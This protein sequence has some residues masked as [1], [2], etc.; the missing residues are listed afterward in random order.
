MGLKEST[1]GY[2]W[3]IWDYYRLSESVHRWSSETVQYLFGLG[4]MMYV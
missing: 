4:L 2:E 1:H 3:L